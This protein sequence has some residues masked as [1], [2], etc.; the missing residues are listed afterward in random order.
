MNCS[1]CDSPIVPGSKFCGKCGQ[2]VEHTE[3]EEPVQNQETVI[4]TED[5]IV[6]HE[7]T[8]HDEQSAHSHQV[9][10]VPDQ[11]AP[12]N[13]P[14][15]GL[16]SLLNRYKIVIGSGLG[17]IVLALVAIFVIMPL[18]Q[19]K[20]APLVYLG[21]NE[22][23]LHLEGEKD[24]IE[25]SSKLVEAEDFEFDSITNIVN[26][27][28][29]LNSK[30]DKM[31]FIKRVTEEGTASLYYRDLKKK[32]S[33]WDEDEGIK[34]ASNITPNDSSAF[35]ITS[36]GNR[37]LYFK[38][39]DYSEGGKLYLHN[40]EEEALV[41]NRVGDYW[42][43]EDKSIIYYTKLDEDEVDLY[44][45]YMNKLDEKS[46]IDSNIWTVEDLDSENGT[47]YYY[48]SNSNAEDDSNESYNSLTLYSKPLNGDKKKLVSNINHL[49]GRIS[50]D[51][52]YYT[53]ATNNTVS[54]IDFVEDDMAEQDGGIIEPSYE[55]YQV[56]VTES[57]ENWYTG[58]IEYY[59]TYNTDYDAYYAAYDKYNDKV[60]RDRIRQELADEV[61][62]DV[63]YTLYLY[64]GGKGEKVT[65]HFYDYRFVD[66]DSKLIFYS[67]NDRKTMNK[68][69]LSE[70]EYASDVVSMYQDTMISS[71]T[72]FVAKDLN[73]DMEF[74]GEDKSTYNYEWSKAN[75]TLYVIEES[76]SD[77]KLVSYEWIDGKLSNRK[78]I[79]EE[80]DSFRYVMEDSLL[81]YY[82]D[83]HE[84]TGELF[85]FE[86]GE[87]KRIANDVS[88][89]RSSYYTE[90][91][92]LFYVTDYDDN[93]SMGT[94]NQYKNKTAEK[95]A[96]DVAR[97]Y[98]NGPS[99]LYYLTEY[100][101][102]KGYGELMKVGE[103][104]K[105]TLIADRVYSIYE[106]NWGYIF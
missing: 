37:V 23:M 75:N 59:D 27:I 22:L 40:L 4:T 21:N 50:N 55:D 29:Q 68:V 3:V 83:V 69:K 41:D 51:S 7:V 95:V 31:F 19:N 94:L 74:V 76:D 93:Q 12:K 46:K 85:V 82:K 39:Y 86:K 9:T 71:D 13:N 14:L 45:V 84:G 88:L 77:S 62:E 106:T 38:S 28:V 5:P 103:K 32:P 56:T 17:V 36:D 10:T 11:N 1:T 65:D 8:E 60:E 96:T 101:S 105:S 100:R 98:Y 58:E 87:T 44:M 18:F 104:S 43:S 79:D 47:I 97:Y 66:A 30:Q 24:P 81:Y 42:L 72:V 54:L 57:Y 70:V 91:K 53:V 90:D 25:L 78:V 64:T 61:Y 52:F 67:K 92:V 63:T 102:N 34:L 73:V 26:S 48:K 33:S 16:I 20:T 6:I 2:K 15:N 80:V 35:Q 99:E 89:Y 49:V